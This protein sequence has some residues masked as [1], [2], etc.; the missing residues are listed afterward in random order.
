MDV[1]FALVVWVVVSAAAAL[2]FL[3]GAAVGR[4]RGYE[5]GLA[6]GRRGRAPRPHRTSM[7][8]RTA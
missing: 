4:R 8:A 6:S 5:E 3:V 1:L 2:T 7:P